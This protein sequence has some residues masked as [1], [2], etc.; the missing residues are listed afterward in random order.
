MEKLMSKRELCP[1]ELQMF[2]NDIVTF[3]TMS[4][5]AKSLLQ[6]IWQITLVQYCYKVRDVSR[7]LHKH[8]LHH[9]TYWVNHTDAERMLVWK[10]RI[11]VGN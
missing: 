4:V 1:D 6:P 8:D 2:H 9:F 5:F 3:T 11:S 7:T 10:M